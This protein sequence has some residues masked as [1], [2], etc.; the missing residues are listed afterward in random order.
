MDLSGILEMLEKWQTF[1]AAVPGVI[2]L[3]WAHL[4]NEKR[5]LFREDR[6]RKNEAITLAFTLRSEL[7]SLRMELRHLI[8]MFRFSGDPLSIDDI[9]DME[10]Q[11]PTIFPA[12]T[13]RL[14]LLGGELAAR[15]V[16]C[17]ADISDTIRRVQKWKDA[18]QDLTGDKFVFADTMVSLTRDK[19]INVARNLN[20]FSRGHPLSEHTYKKGTIPRHVM[21][22]H[23]S[24][25][26]VIMAWREYKGYTRVELAKKASIT[27][28]HL[29]EIEEENVTLTEEVLDRLSSA[30]SVDKELLVL[31]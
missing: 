22:G 5:K 29:Q 7:Y 10:L 6:I 3:I 28:K 19:V 30:L 2:A 23:F 9:K 14:G 13:S 16:D 18:N 17:Y 21:M 1:L 15:V 8:M 31:D 12:N 25:E 27:Q 26:N 24:G 11:V 20:E 4:W